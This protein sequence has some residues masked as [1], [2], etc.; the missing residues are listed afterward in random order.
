MSALRKRRPGPGVRRPRRA[1][2]A[3][4]ALSVALGLT[5]CTLIGVPQEAR[6]ITVLSEQGAIQ[7]EVLAGPFTEGTFDHVLVE[8]TARDAFRE[9]LSAE[10]TSG[11]PSFDVVALDAA[12]LAE[13]A[14]A[15]TPLDRFYTSEV[16]GD[17][18]PGV[19][20][21]A[22][23]EGRYVGMPVWV[24]SE[25]LFYRTD[26]FRDD[27]EQAAFEEEY[28]YP[29]APPVDWEQYRDV[30]EFF[31]RD[32]D[33]DGDTDLYGTA[34]TGA[35]ETDWLATVSQA[36]AEAI[37]L[38][39]DSVTV[40][41]AEHVGALDFYRSLLPFAPPGAARLDPAGARISFYQGSLAMMR[42]RGSAYSQIPGNSPVTGKVGVA[43]MIAGPGGVA[44]VPRA[45][46]LAVP[47][48]A[49]YREGAMAFLSYGVD[50]N[51]LML[52]TP[53]RLPARISRF[54]VRAGQEG[55][56]HYPALIE[57]LTS[58]LSRPRPATPNWEGIAE[59]VLVPTIQK[60]LG[61]NTET[62]VLLDE[63]RRQI[64]AILQE[65]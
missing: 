7:L 5:A 58:P 33:G 12:L 23:V 44:G 45:M 47:Q 49:P 26:L 11:Q 24:D 3:G 64:E 61:G 55:F 63:A 1:I 20:E 57:T 46:Y 50:H 6:Q 17:L 18:F 15:L 21:E 30:A 56:E 41:D 42:F 29:L 52:E 32:T 51:E 48:E 25:I 59:A 31:T 4:G 60:A 40:N 27:R 8:T 10:L 19:L 13:Y 39:G 62:Q 43:P 37:V 36:G 2:P 54:Q 9:R 65:G 34:L 53:P 16:R 22:H 28:G 35:D 14:H 38:D